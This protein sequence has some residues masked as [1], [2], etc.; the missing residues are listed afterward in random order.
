MGLMCSNFS[1]NRKLSRYIHYHV[2]TSIDFLQYLEGFSTC[3]VGLFVNRGHSPKVVY[4]ESSALDV[5]EPT[6]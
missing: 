4:T 1:Y 2:Y 6:N 3:F 5:K